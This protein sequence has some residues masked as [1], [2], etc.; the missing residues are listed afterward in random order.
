MQFL[1]V[2]FCIQVFKTP[3]NNN[4]SNMNNNSNPKKRPARGSAAAMLGP[5]SCMVVEL[6]RGFGRKC[7]DGFHAVNIYDYSPSADDTD[8]DNRRIVWAA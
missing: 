3:T 8:K 7:K 2:N 5:D 6:R 4:T 1:K